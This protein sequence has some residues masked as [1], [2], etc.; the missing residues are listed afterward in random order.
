MTRLGLHLGANHRMDRAVLAEVRAHDFTVARVEVMAVD[1]PAERYGIVQ[2]VLDADL[3][4]VVIVRDGS[5]VPSLPRGINVELRNEDDGDLAPAAYAALVPAFVAECHAHDCRPWIGV[6]SN[7]DENSLAWLQDVLRMLPPTG[8]FG[9][10][11]HRYPNGRHAATP[12]RG[13]TSREAEVAVLR[14]IIGDCPFAVTEFGY[15]TAPQKHAG[16]RGWFGLTW[17]W[18]DADVATH[19]AYE[20]AF[21]ARHGATF[22]IAYALNDG[23]GDG[24]LDRYGYRRGDGRWKPVAL[25]VG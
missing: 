10:S 17:R 5:Q 23:P 6:I 1:D 18:S 22:A 12:H 3:A 4:P 19:T 24:V 20:W 14:R 13:F 8:A 7:L 9:V 21:W 16:W 11:V 2:D 15:S 25:T